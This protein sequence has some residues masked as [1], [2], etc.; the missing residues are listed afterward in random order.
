MLKYAAIRIAILGGS[1]VATVACGGGSSGSRA[2]GGGGIGGGGTTSSAGGNAGAVASGGV[3]NAGG[4]VSG[5]TSTGL[6]NSGGGVS[7]GTG[8]SQPTLD[9]SYFDSKCGPADAGPNAACNV[10]LLDSCKAV[11]DEA[12]GSNWLSGI[13][14]GPCLPFLQCVRACSCGDSS[15]Y[16]PCA[17]SLVEDASSDCAAINRSATC[18]ASCN[19]LCPE[20]GQS[21]V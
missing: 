18:G 20:S 12:F 7:D 15:C 16:V 19:D 2:N 5:N 1:L 21:G 9:L 6:L 4:D 13:P 14:T 3:S 10:C 17:V 8:T 11:W